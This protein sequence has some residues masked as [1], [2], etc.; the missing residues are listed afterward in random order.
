M[1]TVPVSHVFRLARHRRA[2]SHAC[3]ELPRSWWHDYAKEYGNERIW[4][5]GYPMAYTSRIAYWAIKN[6][7]Y[8]VLEVNPQDMLFH[9]EQIC[10]LR[11][12]LCRERMPEFSYLDVRKNIEGLRGHELCRRCMIRAYRHGSFTIL[13]AKELGVIARKSLKDATP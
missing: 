6:C 11:C 8:P 7:R 3:W 2:L 13:L 10:G 12:E 4:V 1:S 5:D 9:I